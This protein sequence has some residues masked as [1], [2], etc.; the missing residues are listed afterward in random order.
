MKEMGCR[1]CH[2][3]SNGECGK[4]VF[5][6]DGVMLLEDDDTPTTPLFRAPYREARLIDDGR[7][8]ARR[9]RPHPN[10]SCRFFEGRGQ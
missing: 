6:E 4:L 10:F 9:F 2:N 1:W 3:Y 7:S 8:G 5:D